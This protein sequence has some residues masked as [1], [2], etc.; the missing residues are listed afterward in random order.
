MAAA[1]RVNIGS[2]LPGAPLAHRERLVNAS[3][4]RQGAATVA[5]TTA[6]PLPLMLDRAGR[7]LPL[8]LDEQPMTW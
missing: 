8:G 5:S 1:E 4:C 7:M 6:P 3:S 2:T